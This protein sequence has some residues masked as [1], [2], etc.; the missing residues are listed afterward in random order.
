MLV[1]RRALGGRRQIASSLKQM[2]QV[3]QSA[4]ASAEQ[5]ANSTDKM[6]SQSESLDGI[7]GRLT[8]LIG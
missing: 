5:N 8:V 6:S 1:C 7:V 4:A 3:T 2:E